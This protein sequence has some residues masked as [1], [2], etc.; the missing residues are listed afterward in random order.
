MSGSRSSNYYD[1]PLRQYAGGFGYLRVGGTAWS[2][3]YSG[4]PAGA[5]YQRVFGMGYYHGFANG[6]RLTCARGTAPTTWT[7]GCCGRRVSTS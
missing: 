5:S 6:T 4:R 1:A 3:L 2:T 7:S